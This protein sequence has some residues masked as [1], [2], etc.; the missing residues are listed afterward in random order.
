LID[1]KGT[2]TYSKKI[3]EIFERYEID[4]KQIPLT[5]TK[6]S[7]NPKDFFDAILRFQ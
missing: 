4:L 6:F 1:D 5:T 7:E 2:K 3:L